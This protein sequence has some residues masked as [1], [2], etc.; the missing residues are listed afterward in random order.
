MKS[1]HSIET[2]FVRDKH[3]N[4]LDFGN[5]RVPAFSA[6]D[7]W[8]VSEK[9]DGTNVR[10]IVT[11]AGIEIRGRTDNATL[12][13]E[14]IK[15]VE[16]LFDHETLLDYFTLYR[17]KALP[18]QWSVTFYGEGYGAG[19]QKGGCYCP[20]KRFRCFDLL[21]GEYWWTPD[22]EMR[23]VCYDL[24]IPV[25]PC[26]IES[27]VGAPPVT[28]EGLM[29]FFPAH[30][31]VVSFEDSGQSGILPEGVVAKPLVPLFDTH[32]DRVLWKLTFREFEKQPRKQKERPASLAGEGE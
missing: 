29:D 1:Y 31:S 4:L 19:I 7:C 23:R 18:E 22:S 3:T 12:H 17:G 28:R 10:V 15:A 6:V 27:Y 21:L 30:S 25:V 8:T 11:L 20:E 9:V 5:I 2:V 13:P 26:L 16:A 14:L 24:G 32:G